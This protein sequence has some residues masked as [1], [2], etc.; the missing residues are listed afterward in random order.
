MPD[1]PETKVSAAAI[2]LAALIK[3]AARVIHQ[4]HP[5]LAAPGCIN[6]FVI[7]A[8]MGAA[9]GD[10]FHHGTKADLAGAMETFREALVQTHAIHAQACPACK[11]RQH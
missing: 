4:Q 8:G 1:D 5:D 2:E 6:P 7:A 10:L 3:A 9:G 11:A